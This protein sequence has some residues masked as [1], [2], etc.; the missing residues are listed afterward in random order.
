MICKKLYNTMLK[1]RLQTGILICKLICNFQIWNWSKVFEKWALVT[2]FDVG[3]VSSNQLCVKF[4]RLGRI[5]RDSRLGGESPKSATRASRASRLGQPWMFAHVDVLS[6]LSPAHDVIAPLD[7][8]RVVLVDRRISCRRESHGGEKVAEVDYFD[9]STRS[10]IVISLS[11]GESNSL[12]QL[13]SPCDR[14]AV[15][16]KEIAGR[17]VPWQTLGPVRVSK[18]HKAIAA[19]RS[20]PIR[21]LPITLIPARN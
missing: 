16:Q 8:R 5:S 1:K 3:I 14:S 6:T 13:S 4:P 15:I 19:G 10:R 9:S 12:L 7:A 20:L 18:T 2:S 17:R 21:S 11:G